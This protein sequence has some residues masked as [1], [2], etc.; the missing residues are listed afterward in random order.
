MEG[1]KDT[2]AAER[3]NIFNSCCLFGLSLSD[4]H[5]KKL[6]ATGCRTLV[7][8]M[9]QDEAG[10]QAMEDIELKTKD[11]F[12]L[13]NLKNFMKLGQDFADISID[14]VEKE[15]KPFLKT[16]EVK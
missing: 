7:I 11:Y 13:T 3:C 15:I 6:I 2:W 5:L 16:L 10:I 14:T 1:P 9:D 8:A 12:K 4:Y